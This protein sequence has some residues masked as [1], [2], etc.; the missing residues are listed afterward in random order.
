MASAVTFQTS[1]K[2]SH[3]SPRFTATH[4]H[5]HGSRSHLRTVV[6]PHHAW[7]T[8]LHD[9]NHWKSLLLHRN[10]PYN[11]TSNKVSSQLVLKVL[12]FSFFFFLI[13]PAKERKNTL[14]I[15]GLFKKIKKSATLQAAT[16]FPQFRSQGFSVG[17]FP[18][19]F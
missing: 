14:S 5:G 11:E 17:F 16:E 13:K 18:R 15:G 12:A 4:L 1:T 19:D 2:L 3:F 7:H 8:G 10:H 9:R 6:H